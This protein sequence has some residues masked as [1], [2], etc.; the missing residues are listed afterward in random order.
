MG[1]AFGFRKIIAV[2][3]GLFGLAMFAHVLTRSS[4]S[5]RAQQLGAVLPIGAPSYDLP[6]LD[7]ALRDPEVMDRRPS[8]DGD[9]TRLAH[10]IKEFRGDLSRNTGARAFELHEQAYLG[11]AALAYYFEDVAAGRLTEG[12]NRSGAVASLSS[13]RSMVTMHATSAARLAGGDQR[14]KARAQ[15]HAAMARYATGHDRADAVAELTRLQS[16]ALSSDLK[17]R[18]AAVAGLANISRGQGAERAKAEASLKRSAASLPPAGKVAIH[19][20]L[21]RSLAGISGDRRVA[22]THASYRAHLAAAARQ[23]VNLTPAEQQHAV[24]YIIGVW[25]AAEGRNLD[26]RKPPFAISPFA[27]QVS[28]KGIIERAALADYAAGQ[29]KNAIRKYQS[30]AQS[31]TGSPLRAD[32]DLRVLDL[33][34]GE[35]SRSKDVNPYVNALLAMSK[36]YLDTGILGNGNEPRAK[37]V[38][39]EVSRR[40]RGLV[41]T[42]LSRSLKESAGERKRAI[43]MAETYLGT[44]N[45]NAEIEDV[46]S[47]IALVYVASNNHRAA[48]GIY[49]ELAETGAANKSRG[50]L[51]LAIRSQSVLAN[52]SV[53]VAWMG[54]KPG[55]T[56]EREELYTLYR[57]L[58]EKD[59]K[60]S[61]W[62]VAAQLGLLDLTMGRP[63]QAFALWTDMLKQEPR[64]VNAANAAGTM[65]VA[66]EKAHAW[67][68]L[69]G[70][71]RLA[72]T[73]NLAP[74]YRGRS[75]AANTMLAVAL[76]EGGKEALA[77]GRFDAAV[78]K[79]AEFVSKHPSAKNH[80]EGFFLLASA[81]HGAGQHDASIK[82]LL[83]FVERYPASGYFR[84]A[85]LNGGDWAAPMAYEENTIY[86]YGRFVKTYGADAEGPRVRSALAA[87][88]EG[89]GIYADAIA[90]LGLTVRAGNEPPAAK[91]AA[92]TRIMDLEERFGTTAR[93]ELAGDLLLKGANV[94]EDT[95]AEA[96]ALKARNAAVAGRY[97]DVQRIEA[98]LVNLGGSQPTQNALGEVRLLLALAKSRTAIKDYF[99]LELR[100]PQATLAQR[101][102]AYK[103]VRTA[104]DSVCAAGQ[105]SACAPAMHQLARFSESFQRSIEDITV[106]STLAKEVV[107]RFTAYK[108][109]IYNDATGTSQ[110]ADARAVAV[111]G[112]GFTG[113]DMTQAVLWQNS[114]DW[115]FERV[116]GETGN[117]YVQWQASVPAA[118]E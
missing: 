23:A 95:K 7:Q 42:E 78:L 1:A 77:Q 16:A 96:Y 55:N 68:A 117:G 104:F 69:E 8:D 26:W 86:F 113:P 31:L 9:A 39:A 20:T 97:A 10:E 93:A 17:N 84:Q 64:G 83:A 66:Y 5:W 44:I 11:A 50:Y 35:F 111:V 65:L 47:K 73:Q 48:V 67:E 109:G 52:W 15:F 118:A 106:Q 57:K 4:Q 62:F 100:D 49:K 60:G 43:A 110:R 28:V 70:I 75:I 2:V 40:Y 74:L 114:S 6:Y 94:S 99:N 19:L 36:N 29:T 103:D 115:N 85:L 76:L 79:L 81:Q 53:D 54:T 33:Q 102:S 112:E 41:H 37:A 56:A 116:S 108:Q 38:A 12:A 45:D 82:T 14:A 72:V 46:K 24:N 51:A 63:E 87:L 92:V 98:S 30:L 61:A 90:V 91:V 59:G 18:A 58:G 13:V 25:R 107:N 80:D 89:R 22:G 32:I 27:N 105:T 34:R 71:A 21:A 3:L 88:Y 101:Y